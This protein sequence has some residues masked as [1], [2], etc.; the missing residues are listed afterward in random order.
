MEF[1]LILENSVAGN[2]HCLH[3]HSTFHLSVISITS[4]VHTESKR[5]YSMTGV[6]KPALCMSRIS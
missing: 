6:A 3:S 2:K 1:T 5:S 4:L